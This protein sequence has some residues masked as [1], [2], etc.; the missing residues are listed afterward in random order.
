MWIGLSKRYAFGSP[1]LPF[2]LAAF[3][4]PGCA[5]VA[6]TEATFFV[7]ADAQ[8]RAQLPVA[9]PND[10]ALQRF[11]VFAQAASFAPGSNGLG[12]LFAGGLAAKIP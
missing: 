2:D 8:G 1:I 4:A 7:V 5:V 12:W 6:S 9:I 11:T 3:G 10:P